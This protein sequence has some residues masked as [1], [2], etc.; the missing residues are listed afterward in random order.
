VTLAEYLAAG[1]AEPQDLPALLAELEHLKAE[2]WGRLMAMSQA[3]P[4]AEDAPLL[5]VD[6]ASAVLNIPKS[7]VYDLA[8]QGKIPSIKVGKYLRF[9]RRAL[10]AMLDAPVS[11]VYS[12]RNG[13]SGAQ[14]ATGATGTHAASA[15][16]K[17]R[18]P[19]EHRGAVGARRGADSRV[20]GAVAGDAGGSA[21]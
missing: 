10:M 11:T 19:L 2:L 7:Y 12:Q 3:P 13:R 4:P 5:D 18:R 15:R 17:G 1:Q 6:E 21:A 14:A 20:N 8:R 9:Q 16:G